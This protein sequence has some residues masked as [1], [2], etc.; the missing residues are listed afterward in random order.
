MV[1]PAPPPGLSPVVTEAPVEPSLR[2]VVQPDS[3]GAPPPTQKI[4]IPP[5]L[6]EASLPQSLG[7]D[8]LPLFGDIPV[9]HRAAFFAAAKRK[10]LGER[11]FVRGFAL[12]VVLRGEAQVTGFNSEVVVA[13]LRAGSVL[14]ARGTAGKALA[15]RLSARGGGCDVVTWSE[16][17][18]NAT[19]QSCPWVDGELRAASNQTL[20]LVGA[21]SG[22]LG[23]LEVRTLEK[24]TEWLQPRVLGPG[25]VALHEGEPTPP[26]LVVG[27]GTVE[28]VRGGGAPERTLGPGELVTPADCARGARAAVTARAGADGAV[29][30]VVDKA[31]RQAM[32]AALPAVIALLTGL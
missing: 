30:M 24:L 17:P 31:R 10:T 15:M 12:G 25:E 19:F 8:D 4:S 32:E 5:E 3:I 21:A 26:L 14:R 9:E 27:T 6:L 1:P 18:L 29:V 28:I 22:V 23:S 11:D 16:A 20:G 2:S 13:R 7:L